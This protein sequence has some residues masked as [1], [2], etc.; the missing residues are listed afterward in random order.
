[1]NVVLKRATANKKLT[2]GKR[3]NDVWVLNPADTYAT[4]PTTCAHLPRTHFEDAVSKG[5]PVNPEPTHA[6]YANGRVAAMAVKGG[7]RMSLSDAVDVIISEAPERALIRWAEVGDVMGVDATD[8]V[9]TLRRIGDER[10]DVTFIGYTH[11]WRVLGGVGADIF[12]AS[13][14][15]PLDVSLAMSMG[16]RPAMTVP[17]D[18]TPKDAAAFEPART[19][20]C[21]AAQRPDVQS[22]ITCGACDTSPNAVAFPAHG[23]RK[24]HAGKGMAWK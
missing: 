11:A 22:C 24:D 12:R 15:T 20:I 19:F 7:E 21:P 16:Y 13:C 2:G 18:W 23:V 9:L 3:R 14:E 17:E 8:V 5:L 6:C 10:P 4:C 1:M